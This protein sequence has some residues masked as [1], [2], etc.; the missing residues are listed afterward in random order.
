MLTEKQQNLVVGMLAE[1]V[2]WYGEE[3]NAAYCARLTR[4]E[5]LLKKVAPETLKS[6][7]EFIKDNYS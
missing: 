5:K 1:L 7:Q 3:D 6:L 2:A 4:A